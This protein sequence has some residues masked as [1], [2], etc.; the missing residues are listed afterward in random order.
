MCYLC[1]RWQPQ[2]YVY[3]CEKRWDI[4]NWV[5]IFHRWQLIICHLFHR[6]SSK[7]NVVIFVTDDTAEFS[8]TSFEDHNLEV[9]GVIFFTD[10]VAK[11]TLSSVLLIDKSFWQMT[12]QNLVSN[13]LR[14]STW[15]V[16]CDLFTDEVAKL[17]LSSFWQ[18]TLQNS[19]S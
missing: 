14:I 10:E 13:L 16:G 5:F 9:W 15:S 18:M 11:L 3:I 1:Q 2:N 7:N 4:K 19:Y 8:A 17:K 12:Q 6:W